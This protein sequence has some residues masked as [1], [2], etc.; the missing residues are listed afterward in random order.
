MMMLII[1]LAIA[2]AAN[3]LIQLELILQMFYLAISLIFY[4][5]VDDANN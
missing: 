1:Y 4:L 2:K 5:A 3:G